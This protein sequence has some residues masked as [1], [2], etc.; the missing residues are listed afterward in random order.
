M[1][2]HKKD[3]SITLIALS[4][5]IAYEMRPPELSVMSLYDWIKLTE[6]QKIPKQRKRSAGKHV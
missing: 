2:T 6:K 1:V 5:L 3:D 4:P